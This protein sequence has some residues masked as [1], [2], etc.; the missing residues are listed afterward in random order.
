LRW[1]SALNNNPGTDCVG[2]F[3][4]SITLRFFIVW[5]YQGRDANQMGWLTFTFSLQKKFEMLF[6]EKLEVMKTQQV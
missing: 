3:P 2:F 4:D 5:I 6:G 1:Q